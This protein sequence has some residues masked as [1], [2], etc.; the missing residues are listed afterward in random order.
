[1]YTFEKFLGAIAIAALGLLLLGTVAFLGGFLVWI[2]WPHTAVAVF[3][4]PT[5]TFWQAVFTTWICSI[6]FKGN[7]TQ[8]MNKS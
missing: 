2:L 4:L 7:C 1:M 5:L 6:L 3:G 8:S